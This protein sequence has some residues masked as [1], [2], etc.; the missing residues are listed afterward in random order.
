MWADTLSPSQTLTAGRMMV[1][2]AQGHLLVNTE[3]EPSL[4]D[5]TLAQATFGM[6]GFGT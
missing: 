1:P 3:Q 2:G 5:C 4:G 6:A